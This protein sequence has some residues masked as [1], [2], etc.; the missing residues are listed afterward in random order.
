MHNPRCPSPP[1][2]VLLARLA[3]ESKQRRL[4]ETR[5][6]DRGWTAKPDPKPADDGGDLIGT[7]IAATLVYGALTSE[8]PASTDSFSGGGGDFGGGG[9]SGSFD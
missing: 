8:A 2:P 3:N 7:A 1:D 5:P 4:G 9:A 6:F